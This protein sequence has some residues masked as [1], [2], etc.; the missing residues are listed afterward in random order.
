[1]IHPLVGIYI[2]NDAKTKKPVKLAI[3]HQRL[4]LV[5]MFST[6]FST[7]EKGEVIS[8]LF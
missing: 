6:I 5:M 8:F 3:Y 4:V 1:V 7:I 2:Y